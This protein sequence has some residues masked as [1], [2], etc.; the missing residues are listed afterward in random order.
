MPKK[1]KSKC[2]R[3]TSWWKQSKKKEPP[4]IEHQIQEHNLSLPEQECDPKVLVEQETLCFDVAK[5]DLASLEQNCDASFSF[6]VA[7]VEVTSYLSSLADHT[8]TSSSARQDVVLLD[9][10]GCN[11]YQTDEDYDSGDDEAIAACPSSRFDHT[12]S[13]PTGYYQCM[14]SGTKTTRGSQAYTTILKVSIQDSVVGESIRNYASTLPNYFE[15]SSPTELSQVGSLERIPPSTP[16]VSTQSLDDTASVPCQRAEMSVLASKLAG[17]LPKLWSADYSGGNLSIM[18]QSAHPCKSTQ[19]TIILTSESSYQLY[20]HGHEIAPDH[21]V[22]QKFTPVDLQVM[23]ETVVLDNLLKTVSALRLFEVC[24]GVPKLKYKSLW[25]KVDGCARDTNPYQEIRYQ[26]TCRAN[27]CLRIIPQTKKECSVCYDLQRKFARKFKSQANIACSPSGRVKT[28]KKN[29]PNKDLST[30]ERKARMERLC[31]TIK[32]VK[33]QNQRLREKLSKLIDEEGVEVDEEMDQYLVDIASDPE[34]IDRIEKGVPGGIENRE[35]SVDFLKIFFEQQLKARKLQHKSGMRWHPLLIRFALHVRET[36]A[37]AYR[38]L[39]GFLELP[40]E[41]TLFDYSH[42]Y[43]IQEG[44]HSDIIKDVAE[45]VAGFRH[46]YQHYHSILLDE[47]YINQNLVSRKSDGSVV[48]YCHLDDVTQELL[49]LQHTV[50]AA[51]EGVPVTPLTPPL[52]KTM[53]TYMVKGTSSGIKNVVAAYSCAGTTKEDLYRHS[54][55]VVEKCE[56]SG[57]KIIAIVCDGSGLNRA[58]IDMNP[59]KTTQHGVTFDTVNPYDPSRSIFFISDVPHLVK[60]VRNCFSNSGY[61]KGR[62][63]FKNGEYIL[64]STIVDLFKLKSTQTVKKLHKLTAGCVY[65]NRFSCQNT[66]LAF[67]VLSQSVANA[68]EE[69]QWPNTKETRIFK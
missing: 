52:A 22:F 12:Y 35:E 64:W 24:T 60:T 14:Q 51:A 45:R 33:R 21:E 47:I 2:F 36:S 62:K 9:G 8:Y 58:F 67:R 54:W 3:R 11:S 10:D 34:T 16:C 13:K 30:P 49:Q 5:D 19:R 57:I 40:S 59:P 27:N 37:S 46:S 44:C 1:S 31:K 7:E 38:E 48:G 69:L 28:P 26:E 23:P 55:E 53:M 56:C 29:K 43:K 63:L 61:K 6:D 32:N 39:R 42:I 41:R 20:I 68:L 66:K 65:L 18:K 50:A 17:L 25:G 15:M 4:D